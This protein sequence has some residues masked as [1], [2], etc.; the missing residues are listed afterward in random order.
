MA[1]IG[2]MKELESAIEETQIIGYNYFAVVVCMQ[3][4]EDDEIIINTNANSGD[5]LAYYQKVYDENLFHKFSDGIRIIGFAYGDTLNE[6]ETE[7]MSY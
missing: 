5:K 3:D 2:T 1:R 6:I 4:F 7:L